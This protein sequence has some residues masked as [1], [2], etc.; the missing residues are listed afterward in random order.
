[1]R[2]LRLILTAI[3]FVLP[4][5]A[6]S[7]SVGP[8][9]IIGKWQ[10]VKQASGF[11]VIRPDSSMSNQH[12]MEYK[13]SRRWRLRGDTLY[14]TNPALGPSDKQWWT[15]GAIKRLT[16][17]EL[18]VVWMFQVHDSTTSI[19]KRVGPPTPRPDSVPLPTLSLP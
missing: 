17:Q 5:P 12:D 19:Y 18:E 11:W 15:R 9:N 16:S 1:M 7:Q 13:M 8:A 3:A 2:L 14:M 6:L 10:N 4:T